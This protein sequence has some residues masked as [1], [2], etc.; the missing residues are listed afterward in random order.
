MVWRLVPEG[1]V[2]GDCGN[3]RWWET[4]TGSIRSHT[5]Q[6][7]CR[8]LLLFWLS[9][10]NYTWSDQ[11]F[12]VTNPCCGDSY[13]STRNQTNM[14]CILWN[15]ESKKSLFC[16]FQVS[17]QSHKSLAHV[18]Q[19]PTPPTQLASL[20]TFPWKSTFPYIQRLD[21]VAMTSHL[22]R[23]PLTAVPSTFILFHGSIFSEIQ[24][25]HLWRPALASATFEVCHLFFVSLMLY[26]LRISWHL[27]P[28]IPQTFIE[29]IYRN[30]N[31]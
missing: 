22:H 17:G 1:A 14:N 2:W 3:W 31:I 9:E 21:S 18:I 15:H 20:C 30:L 12:S 11:L 27:V 23:N 19:H 4:A 7:S 29:W 13:T 16:F 6:G 10:V 24:L 25:K 28:Y 8:W 5:R 26:L